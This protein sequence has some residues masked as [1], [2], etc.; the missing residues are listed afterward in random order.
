MFHFY[1]LLTPQAT[2][3]S[4]YASQFWKDLYFF[5]YLNFQKT[6][7]MPTL[8]FEK[9]LHIYLIYQE[10]VGL[11]LFLFWINMLEICQVPSAKLLNFLSCK[12]L[13]ILKVFPNITFSSI[14]KWGASFT[15]SSRDRYCAIFMTKR[16][17]T[18]CTRL[19]DIILIKQFCIYIKNYA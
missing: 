16:T 18:Y 12:T 7:V 5:L 11:F 8:L 17:S 14:Q 3:T 13:N 6:K 15:Y 2:L 10:L 9:F 4:H 1:T 19:S